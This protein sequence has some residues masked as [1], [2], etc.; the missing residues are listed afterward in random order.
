M[1]P[2]LAPSVLLLLLACGG[3]GED[4]GSSTESDADTDADSDTDVN[5]PS[6]TGFITEGLTGAKCGCQS[7]VAGAAAPL[8]GLVG[9]L[10]LGLRRRRTG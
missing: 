1:K 9:V 7:G 6:D 10:T 5:D 4:S 8:A 2:L 3:K